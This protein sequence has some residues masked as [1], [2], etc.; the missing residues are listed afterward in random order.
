MDAEQ[1]RTIAEDLQF[2]ATEWGGDITS[3]EIRRGTATLRRLLVE[4]TYS[5]AWRAAGFEREPR[6]IAV[7]LENVFSAK[8]LHLIDFAL[9]HGVNLRGLQIYGSIVNKGNVAVERPNHKQLTDD[10]YPGERVFGMAEYIAS[11]AGYAFGQFFTRRDV[12][13]Y[14]AS[15]KGAVHLNSKARPQE[16][17]LVA[18]VAKIDR[19]LNVCGI[20]GIFIEALAI[21]QAIGRSAD[22]KSF[23]SRSVG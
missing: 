8:D 18:R 2:L 14:M 17:K 11:N 9:A 20:D 15:V 5:N 10:G 19:K 1:L 12:I 23:I 13:K 16:V 3:P 6:V 21:A 7:D 4:N 22:A